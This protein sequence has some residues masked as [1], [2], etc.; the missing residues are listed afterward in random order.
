VVFGPAENEVH[1]VDDASVSKSH[2]ITFCKI[3]LSQIYLNT[4]NLAQN[5]HLYFLR[6]MVFILNLD[7]ILVF[8]YVYVLDL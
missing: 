4:F 2:W 5:K 1:F 8:N 6:N 3:R 7:I